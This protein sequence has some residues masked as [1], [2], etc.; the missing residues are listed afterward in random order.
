MSIVLILICPSFIELGTNPTWV[1]FLAENM[2]K[3]K[4][5]IVEWMI[6]FKGP[7]L[8][9]KYEDLQADAFNEVLRILDFL[10]FDY[11]EESIRRALIHDFRFVTLE[12]HIT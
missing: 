1:T 2:N 4:N 12:S 3:W 5:M 9:V 11:N 6:K 7:L 10:E 8:V